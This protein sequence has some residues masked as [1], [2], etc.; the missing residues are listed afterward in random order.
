[1]FNYIAASVMVFML[2]DV[3]RPAGQMDPA[4][5]RFPEGTKLPTLNHIP[6]F[7]LIF[8]KDVPANVTFLIALAMAVAVWA[9]LWRTRLGYQIRAFGK[10]ESAA[11]YAGI[12][13]FRIIMISMIISGG[14]CG[15]MA[16]NNVMGEAER[17]VQN[18]ASGAGFIGIAVALM[19]RNHPVGV[20]LAAV[21]FGFLF[22]GGAELGLWTKIPIELRTV[23]QGLVILF[24]GAL[25]Y[26]VRMMLVRVFGLF[27]AAAKG[28]A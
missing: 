8:Q 22:Q 16:I 18:S 11:R 2:V 25:D 15:M 21:L 26:M 4:S 1:M 28:V 24:T 14:L 17:L 3:L 13:P 27:P 12:N 23:V 7:D 9:L 19:G 20:V 5:A 10:S 6:G